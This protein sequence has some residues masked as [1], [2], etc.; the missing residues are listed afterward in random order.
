MIGTLD[1]PSFGSAT[2]Y[3]SDFKNY[4][5][6]T[7]MLIFDFYLLLI[8]IRL[9]ELNADDLPHLSASSSLNLMLTSMVYVTIQHYES[10]NHRI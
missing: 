2:V 6:D 5:F 8:E 10:Q 1:F 7:K 9:T 4:G 3:C